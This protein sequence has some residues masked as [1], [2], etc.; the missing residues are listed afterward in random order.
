MAQYLAV[1]NFKK[2]QHYTD[3]DPI[4]IKFYV[5]VLN[6][7][8]IT[9]MPEAAQCQLFKFWL[10]ASRHSNRIPYDLKHIREEI[11]PGRKLYL[12]DLI[13]AGLIEMVYENAS[14]GLAENDQPRVRV[15]RAGE[16]EQRLEVQRLEQATD[17]PPPP[18]AKLGAER[19]G[20]ELAVLRGSPETKHQRLQSLFDGWREGLGMPQGQPALDVDVDVGLREYV[21]NND[22][23]DF[24]AAH[25]ARYVSKAKTRRLSSDDRPT[26]GRDRAAGWD[27][28]A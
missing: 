14:A 27:H 15:A 12:D 24:N 2:H 23:P 5:A 17:T 18:R 11:R 6:D 9:R 13:E 28:V 3:R 25:M 20:G 16:E 7:T 21:A 1:K 26:K 4:W 22:T 8:V 19:T 10:L